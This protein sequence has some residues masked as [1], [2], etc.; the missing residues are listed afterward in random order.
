MRVHL[1]GHL[2]TLDCTC[3]HSNLQSSSYCALPVSHMAQCWWRPLT[4]LQPSCGVHSRKM[5]LFSTLKLNKDHQCARN[6]DYFRLNFYLSLSLK[7]L[8]RRSHDDLEVA[9]KPGCSELSR[10]GG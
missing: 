1:V 6:N 4:V 3:M 2:S 8:V 7:L 10:R 9:R 5:H